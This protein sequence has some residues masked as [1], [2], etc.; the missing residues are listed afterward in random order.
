MDQRTSD[1]EADLKNILQTRLALADKLQFLER[2]VEE[3]VEETK[4]AVLDL[5]GHAKNTAAEFVE[6]TTA[7]LN[8]AV[9]ATKRPW[10]LVGG[11]IAVGLIAGWL[12]QRKRSSG[13]YAYAPPKA[14]PATVMPSEAESGGPREGVYPFYTTGE[15]QTPPFKP[16]RYARG[17]HPRKDTALKA[18][19]EIKSLLGE[20][21]DE[22]AK[23]RERLKVAAIETGRT[24]LQ[25]LAHIAVQSLIDSLS[26]KPGAR[27]AQL[28][29][30]TSRYEEAAPTR[31]R[32]AA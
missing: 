21:T 27:S 3:T 26:R 16:S 2:R 20:F 30:S 28:S 17:E 13:R 25:E 5:I 14:H 31:P 29:D 18:V 19:G 32:A 15:S 12:E 24:F 9:Q 11:A 1:I 23:E 6:S 4:Q 22:F 10:M 7:Q 8:P